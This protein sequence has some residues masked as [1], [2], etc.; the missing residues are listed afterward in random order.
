MPVSKAGNLYFTDEQYKYARYE[1]SALEYAKAQG[2]ELVKESGRYYHLKEHDSMI[3]TENGAWYWNSYNQKGGALEFIMNYEGKTFVEAVLALNNSLEQERLN[4]S[5]TPHPFQK[6]SEEHASRPF[7]LPEKSDSFKRL[8]AYLCSTRKLD[9]EIVKDLVDQG[10][11]YESVH[12]FYV[13]ET[14]KENHNAVFVGMD[15]DGTPRSAFQRGVNTYAEKPFKRDVAGS[16]KEF[17]FCVPGH[18]NII[19][20]YVFEASIDA[21]SHA[22]L[23]KKSG[24]DYKTADRIALGGVAAA[25]L[26]KYLE[27]HRD[28]REIVLSLDNDAAGILAANRIH[29]ELMQQG[30]VRE[31]GYSITLDVPTYAKDWNEVLQM[32]SSNNQREQESPTSVEQAPAEQQE[33]NDQEIE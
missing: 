13:G 3:F 10:R 9:R 24:E 8:F 28:I 22:T 19:K 5:N 33:E 14:A 4:Q 15:A 1:T 20:V 17:A 12:H 27:T 11:L 23:S 31:Y 26:I 25:P 6:H 7:E 2:Y 30:Y 16:Q 21:I 18:Q 29:D 32:M